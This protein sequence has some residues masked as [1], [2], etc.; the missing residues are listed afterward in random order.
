MAFS[1]RDARRQRMSAEL[2]DWCRTGAPDERRTLVLKLAP[3]ADLSQLATRL[4]DL[5]ATL[6]STGPAVT[7]AEVSCNAAGEAAELP[8]VVSADLPA[9]LAPKDARSQKPS[10]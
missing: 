9:R 6:V 1:T 8:G 7:I 10:R 2:R 3:G 4:G 5:G